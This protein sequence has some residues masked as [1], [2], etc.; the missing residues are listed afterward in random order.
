MSNEDSIR[1][2]LAIEPPDELLR[3]I[4]SIQ[5]SLRMSCPF[6]IR[7][8]KP[9]GI[10]ITLKFFG[11]ISGSDIP[12]ISRL[13]EHYTQGIAPLY[14]EVKNLGLFPSLKRPRVLWIG[15]E[16]DIGPLILLQKNLEQAF[17][18]MGFPKEERPFRPHVTVGRIKTPRLT[19]DPEKFM[20]Q[21][22]GVAAGNFPAEGLGLYKSELTPRG[23]LYTRLSWFPFGLKEV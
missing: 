23:A 9:A 3:E 14:L 22:S 17:A 13:A 12:A 15:M 11:T 5:S 2:F 10:H 19:A 6:D 16:G 4:G 21:S 7:W 18:G 8:V 20:R 1:A